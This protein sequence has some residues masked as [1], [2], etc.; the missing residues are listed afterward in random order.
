M[1]RMDRCSWLFVLN[2]VPGGRDAPMGGVRGGDVGQEI[3]R[4]SEVRSQRADR[5]A[6]GGTRE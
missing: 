6:E 4:R 1:Q 3:G 2:I 5:P